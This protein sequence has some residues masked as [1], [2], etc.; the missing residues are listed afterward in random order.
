M[1]GI[2]KDVSEE[3]ITHPAESRAARSGS[4]PAASEPPRDLAALGFTA[5]FQALFDPLAGKGLSPGRVSRVDRGQ[6]LVLTVDGP[7]RAELAAHLR[8]SDDTRLAVGDWVALARPEG[9]DLAIVEAI[10]PRTSAFTR[11]DPGEHTVGQVLAANVDVLFIVQSLAPK[12]PNIARLERELVLAWE[13]GARP[14]VVLTKGDLVPRSA[15]VREEVAS[16]ALGVDVH[17]A[18]GITGE[19]M[20][21]L[22]AH[23]LGPGCT[24][25]F[26]GASGV[27]KSTLVNR[28]IG[29]EV[30]DTAEVRESDGKGRHTTVAREMFFLADGSI[31]IDTPGMRALALWDSEDGISAAFPD[32]EEHAAR[33][34]FA[35]CTHMREPGCAV[36]GAVERGE[37][38]ERRL[39]SYLRLREE[40][41][42]LATRQD[43]RARVE[44]KRGDK[45]LV[46]EIK[47]FY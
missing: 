29:A 19:G 25:A 16:V 2:L 8:S 12:G 44:K 18:S 13:S 17:V 39:D 11:K 22:A 43:V 3:N 31:L 14:V 41:E 36:R 23:H 28:L 26:F 45:L 24:A 10:L 15:A 40:L 7:L 6:P 30:A 42:Q 34:R 37:V 21:E 46:R 5:R 35:D 1:R 4:A 33:C 9:H 47:R 20:E 27:G 32:I 38:H